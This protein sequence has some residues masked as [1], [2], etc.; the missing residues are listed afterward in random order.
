MQP[1][2]LSR[3]RA[4]IPPTRLRHDTMSATSAAP[5]LG[6]ATALAGLL[7]LASAPCAFGA[8]PP[9]PPSGNPP[10]RA[11]ANPA[12][13][14]PPEALPVPRS[15]T[16]THS[17]VFGGTPVT[18]TV[19]AADTFLG[20][21]GHPTATIFAFTYLRQGVRDPSTRP[22]TFIF[23]GGPGSSSIWIHMG[24]LGPR[25]VALGDA[26]H[27]P[28]TGPFQIR[29]NPQ[30]P[31]DA[32]DL[33]FIDPVGTGFS[34]LTG[35]G[36]PEQ[37][38]GVQEDAHA[39][40]EFIEAWLSQ[41]NRWSSP[42]FVLGESYG[43]IRACELAKVLFGGPFSGGS[44]PGVTFNGVILLGTALD[45]GGGDLSAQ[46]VLPSLAAVAWYHGR[47]DKAGRSFESFMR[48]AR[49]FAATDYGTA[50]YAGNRL[51]KDE[52][53]G[54]A[55]RMAAFTGLPERFL[56]EHDLRVSAR[57]FADELLRDADQQVGLYDARYVLPSRGSANDPVADDAAMG[58]YVPAFVAAFHEYLREDLKVPL[59]DSYTVIAFKDV[60]SHWNYGSQ[61]LEGPYAADLAAVMRHVPAMRLLVGS[62]YYDLVT[63]F[64]AA[65]HALSHVDIPLERISFKTYE[66]GHM[67][68]LGV[69]PTQEFI[70]D[71]RAFLAGGHP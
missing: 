46:S 20:E 70:R 10:A 68:Y 48:E 62:G 22:V 8:D 71:L 6:L 36:K 18:Y 55:K 19:T 53:A 23:N 39:T 67:A 50:L 21:P 5:T 43:T 13:A 42:K 34:H 51:S 58:Q 12:S 64:G 7:L 52:R 17:G 25:S 26:V 61:G 2:A 33:V 49:E 38:Y 4:M 59:N 14:V 37:Y 54:I 65:E 11:A 1:P 47:I 3:A 44:L 28:T 31:L 16:S 69:Q 27:P 60:N 35:A 63:P 66:S 30:S 57:Q 56:L 15:F 41:Y 40:A 24:A 32:T 9:P 29:D 45:R